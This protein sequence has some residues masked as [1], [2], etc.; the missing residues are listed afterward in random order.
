MKRYLPGL[1]ISL[2]YFIILFVTLPNYGMNEDSPFHFLR[3]QTYLQELLTGDPKFSSSDSHSPVFFIPGQRIS[4]YKPNASEELSTFSPIRPIGFYQTDQTLQQEHKK[5]II[6][7]GRR[8]SFYKHNAW[9]INYWDIPQNQGH[10][11]VSDM[12]T[13]VTNRVFYEGFGLTGDV[14]GY[15]LF[16]VFASALAVFIV[17]L[18]AK[19]AF[20][21]SAAIFSAL[22]LAL[23]PFFFSES[24]FNI[25]DPVQMSFFSVSVISF[26][27]WISKKF[28]LRWYFVFTISLFLAL[29]TKWNIFFAPVIVLPWVFFLK[30]EVRFFWLR[31][32]AL[33]SLSLIIAFGL[34]I[35]IWPFLWTDSLL[36]L[37]N[38]FTFYGSLAFKDIRIQSPSSFKL[39]LGF[40][41]T[42]LLR[43]ITMTPPPMLIFLFTGLITLILGKVKT[44]YKEGL[45]VLLW[46]IIPILRVSRQETETLGSIR[47]F[48][49]YLPAFAVIC[50]VGASFL[51]MKIQAAGN[52]IWNPGLQ[53]DRSEI[54]KK[55]SV[56]SKNKSWDSLIHYIAPA[57]LI[58]FYFGLLF[59]PL[60]RFHPNENI[61]FNFIAG[62]LKGAKD[63]KLYEWEGSYDNVYRQGIAWFNT[64]AEEKA[65]LAHLDGTML[66]ISPLWLRDDIRYGSFFSGY[67]ARGEY[68]ISLVYPDEPHVF[69]YNYLSK[70]L[71]PVYSL[72]IDGVDVLKIWKNDPKFTNPLYKNQVSLDQKF[73]PKK[74]IL[75]GR[76]IWDI[77]LGRSMTVTKLL[78]NY[79]SHCSEPKGVWSVILK[80][81]EKFLSLNETALNN[82]QK[83]ID[84]PAEQ[85][86]IIR[87][88]DVEGNGCIHNLKVDKIFILE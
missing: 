64:H 53:S 65:R 78:I 59:I 8:D 45:L 6:K 68:V 39:P 17:Y 49:E 54:E 38:T 11:A 5:N 3:G 60:Y 71:V 48:M 80:G 52:K 7:T 69:G 32:F 77:G 50:G 42:A 46:F 57:T 35:M 12:L 76:I 75:D 14:E 51:L 36:K 4:L 19:K 67:A 63:L 31:I 82:D 84:F 66:S 41:A 34:L 2:L 79:E 30:K 23:F 44:R 21:E 62:G 1:I 26:Y 47:N 56:K 18:F 40:N 22:T 72:K 10:P 61:Y 16:V 73:T 85:A 37:V 20:G 43:V 28:S 83:E 86:D 25:K 87:N 9:S 88:W 70:F 33:G 15:H 81:K 24:H 13:A 55:H 29:G 58:L 27:F 74:H